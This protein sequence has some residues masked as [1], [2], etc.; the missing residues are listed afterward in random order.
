MPAEPLVP[1]SET[2]VVLPLAAPVVPD[3]ELPAPP[4][5]PEAEPVDA[6]LV[7]DGLPLEPLV[8]PVVVPLPAPPFGVEELDPQAIAVTNNT[9]AKRARFMTTNLRL[10]VAHV[11][12]ARGKPQSRLDTKRKIEGRANGLRPFRALAQVP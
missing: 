1:D 12:T 11:D 10:S 9:D 6:P 3:V 4:L 2:P 7:V 5:V 8:D